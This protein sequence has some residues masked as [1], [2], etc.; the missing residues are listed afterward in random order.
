LL[1][2]GEEKEEGKKKRREKGRAILLWKGR[3]WEGGGG[4]PEYDHDFYRFKRPGERG[5]GRKRRCIAERKRRRR[6]YTGFALLPFPRSSRLYNRKRGRGKDRKP[7]IVKGG[8]E[9]GE[10]RSER[11]KYPLLHRW[12]PDERGKKKKGEGSPIDLSVTVKKRKR[13]NERKQQHN[14]ETT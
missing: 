4:R 8:G 1:V 3:K 6:D 5:G 11:K 14:L 7:T 2:H 10:E 12:T 13:G 9:G